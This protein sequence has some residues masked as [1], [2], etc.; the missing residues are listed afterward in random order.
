MVHGENELS[1]L[2]GAVELFFSNSERYLPKEK[3]I[4]IL[5]ACK[6]DCDLLCTDIAVEWS[7]YPNTRVIRTLF[8]KNLLKKEENSFAWYDK[9]TEALAKNCC[10]CE[11]VL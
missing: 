9:A 5:K 1:P 7:V 6:E 3:A 8:W 4:A 10:A 11:D 2:N